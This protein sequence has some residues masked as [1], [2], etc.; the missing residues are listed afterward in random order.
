MSQG[1]PK[2]P[3]VFRDPVHNLI[4]FD[5]EDRDLLLAIIQTAEFQRLRRIRQLGLSALTFHGAEHTRFTHSLGTY[6]VAKRMLESLERRKA[7]FPDLFQPLQPH[8]REILVAALLHD[9]GHCPF[10]HVLEKL[11][12]PQPLPPGYAKDHEGWTE[13][14][15]RDIIANTSS[16]LDWEFVGRLYSRIGA[17]EGVARDIISSQLDADRLD[18]LLR[19]SYAAGVPYGRFD[20][21]WLLHSIRIGLVEV[22]GVAGKMPRLCF[23][24]PKAKAVVEQ[25]VLARQCMYLQ[26]Y[27][28]KTTRAYEA[29]LRH[30][31]ELAR[32]VVAGGG[33]LPERTPDP[34]RKALMGDCL[35]LEEYLELD[36]FVLWTVLRD[37]ARMRESKCPAAKLLGEKAD[38]L[39]NR[40]KPYRTIELRERGQQDAAL[41]VVNTL[42]TQGAMEQFSCYRDSYED[43][44]YR[45]IFYKGGKEEEE[46]RV[47]PIYLLDSERNTHLA[48]EQSEVIRA[49]SEVQ[50]EV[51][52]LHYDDSAPGVVNLLQEK[53]LL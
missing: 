49:L 10:S 44:P 5:P 23:T 36:D 26:V 48:E 28:H 18:Y 9:I 41:E 21:E 8:R 17:N 51:Y 7:D 52:R 12:V 19:D 4:T 47:R 20:L 53:R 30:I 46:K 6:H 35:T 37:W 45:N 14:I 31:I 50:M 16:D 25:Y 38:A 3:K 13:R 11:I 43:V 40:R 29:L 15:I 32:F 24:T 39:V 1:P 34:V 33:S 27:V 22:A 2:S 42:R